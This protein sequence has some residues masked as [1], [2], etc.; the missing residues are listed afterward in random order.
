MEWKLSRAGKMTTREGNEG[1]D[2]ILIVGLSLP[3]M[4]RLKAGTQTR[5]RNDRVFTFFL[6]KYSL[7]TLSFFI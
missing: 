3:G 2:Y 5:A 1:L 4:Q 7:T 6:Q